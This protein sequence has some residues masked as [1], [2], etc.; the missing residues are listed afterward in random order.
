MVVYTVIY[1]FSVHFSVDYS[2]NDANILEPP[3]CNKIGASSSIFDL[4]RWDLSRTPPVLRHLLI[5]LYRGLQ[6][7]Y[8]IYIYMTRSSPFPKD[9]GRPNVMVCLG[10]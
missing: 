8:D 5:K 9:S 6:H 3:G 1:I 7:V 2:V 4:C 10:S